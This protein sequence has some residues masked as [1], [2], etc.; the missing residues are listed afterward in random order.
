MLMPQ[1]LPQHVGWQP[2][3]SCVPS[4]RT[5]ESFEGCSRHITKSDGA[6]ACLPITLK[7]DVR[8]VKQMI[9][10]GTSSTYARSIGAASR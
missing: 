2:A 1:V 3:L 7:V 6:A 8:H 10:R 9:G 5:A 4:E